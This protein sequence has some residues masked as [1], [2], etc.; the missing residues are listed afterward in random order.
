M[1]EDARPLRGDQ[2]R[3]SVAVAVEPAIAFRIFTEEIDAWWRRGPAYRS[4]GRKPSVMQLEKG[5]GG[6]LYESFEAPSG[7]RVVE[8][9]RVTAWEPPSRLALEWRGPNFAPAEKT[10]VEVSFDPTPS[11]TLVTVVHR[12]WT[13]IRTDHPARHGLEVSPFIRML[14][15]WWGELMTSLSHHAAPPASD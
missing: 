9:G 13:R 11:G 1:S 6:R 5:V 7:P 8:T 15:L 12:G 10:E 3:V 14:G 2:A 4:A